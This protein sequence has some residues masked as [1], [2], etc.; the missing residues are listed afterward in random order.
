MSK[1]TGTP[2]AEE[3]D[4]DPEPEFPRANA[5]A[6]QAIAGTLASTLGPTPR[7][8]LVVETLATREETRRGVPPTD[9]FVATSDG[10]TILEHLPLEHPVAPIVE[11][12]AGP[13]RPGETDVE[14]RDVPDGVTTSVVLAAALLDEGVDL[15]EKGVHPQSIIRGYDAARAIA[16]DEVRTAARPVEEFDDPDARALNVAKTAMTGND[17]G[18]IADRLAAFAR[19]IVAEVGVPTEKRL[20]VRQVRDGFIADSQLVRGAVL[21][22]NS[23]VDDKMPQRVEDAS[24]LVLGG[25]DRGGLDAPDLDDDVTATV[26]EVEDVEAFEM[27][28]DDWRADVCTSIRQAGVNV[29]VTELGIDSDFNDFLVENDILGIRSVNRLDLAQVARATGATVVSDPRDVA[30]E[31]L[32]HAGIV[33]EQTIEPREGRRKRRRMTVFDD[34]TD[35]DSVCV[36]LRGVDDYLGDQATTDLRK[37]AAAVATA[38]GDADASAGVVPGGGAID[39]RVASAVRD[40]STGEGSRAALAMEAYADAVQQVPH[41]LAHNAGLDPIETLADLRAAHERGDDSG[42]VFPDGGIAD[43]VKAGVVDPAATRLEGYHTA[44]DIATLLLRIDDALDAEF[45]EDEPDPDDVIF[46]EPAEQQQDFLNEQ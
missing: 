2:T 15:V 13:E 46:D 26:E 5:V 9:E 6:V 44:T 37:A 17:V 24:V 19:E 36:V 43:V 33:E 10:A 27:V 3:S 8:K 35:P 29:V 7:D 30:A 41:T 40:A 42:L 38:T 12:M 25:H 21:D 11:R 18:G 16:T 34:C 1:P 39:V 4:L 28:F 31:H 22:R 20:A 23:R 32:G 45:T 14:G